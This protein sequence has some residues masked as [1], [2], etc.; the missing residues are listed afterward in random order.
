LEGFLDHPWASTDGR[1]PPE[2]PLP[3]DPLAAV[4]ALLIPTL[5]IAGDQEAA[6]AIGET[7]LQR[8]RSLQFPYGPFSV[9]FV[10]CFIALTHRMAGDH[11]GAGRLGDDLVQLGER[12]GF[13]AWQ[14]AGAIQAGFTAAREGDAAALDRVVRDVSL[15]RTALASDLWTPFWL[16]ELAG[17]QRRSG[18]LD[19]A[20]RSL[21]EALSVSSATGATFYLAETLRI[22]GEVRRDRGDPDGV[23]DLG[24]ALEVAMSQGAALFAGRAKAALDRITLP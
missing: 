10:M 16:T 13:T 14:L 21:D 8:A 7:A 2:W 3:N 20:L 6:A 15:W 1:P 17:A 9:G 12:H 24:G 22:R 18:H 23:G 19:A 5:W 11:V 4:Q